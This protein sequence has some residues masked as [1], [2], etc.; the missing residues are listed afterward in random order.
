MCLE[1]SEVKKFVFSNRE[2]YCKA[3]VDLQNT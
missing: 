1:E 3:F 2:W